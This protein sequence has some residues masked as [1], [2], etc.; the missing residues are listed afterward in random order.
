V[1]GAGNFVV[2]WQ[3]SAQDGFANG[4]FARRYDSVATPLS[5]EFQVNVHTTDQQQ[6]PRVVLD[7]DGAFVVIWT[8]NHQEAASSQAASSEGTLTVRERPS[9]A[10]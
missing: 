4:I 6:N 8:S 3:S 7:D 1:D 9:A 5:G 2:T 10:R